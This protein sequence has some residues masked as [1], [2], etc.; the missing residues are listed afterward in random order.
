MK[1][2]YALHDHRQVKGIMPAYAVFN[3]ER[4]ATGDFKG[5][6]VPEAGKLIGRE[7]KGLSADAKKVCS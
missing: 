3:A 5:L 4:F 6:K 2:Y 1:G 7:W